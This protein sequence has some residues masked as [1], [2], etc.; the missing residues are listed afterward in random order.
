MKTGKQSRV[1]SAK[2]TDAEDSYAMY[3]SGYYVNSKEN[4]SF[5][6]D[7]EHNRYVIKID[8]H[9]LFKSRKLLNDCKLPCDYTFCRNSSAI[10][11]MIEKYKL[12][13]WFTPAVR[14][15]YEELLSAKL[16][17]TIEAVHNEIVA[18]G[19]FGVA[20]GNVLTVDTLVGL[21]NSKRHRSTS[22]ATL[23]HLI[24]KGYNQG[25]TWVDGEVQHKNNHP[26]ARLG[27]EKVSF[28]EFREYLFCNSQSRNAFIINNFNTVFAADE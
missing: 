25:I 20:L 4:G 13:T 15:I 9:V 22:K 27:E 11:D 8:S 3:R 28:S 5:F 24:L 21:P 17:F 10:L 7:K 23:C 19:L 1:F 2:C 14:E 26:A 6:W 12:K 18:G 16:A